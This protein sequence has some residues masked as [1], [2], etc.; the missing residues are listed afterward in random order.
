MVGTNKINQ[1]KTYK[2]VTNDGEIVEFYRTKATA[3]LE[4]KELE[5]L[6]MQELKIRWCA[7]EYFDIKIPNNRFE[8]ALKEIIS[9]KFVLTNSLHGVIICQAYNIPYAISLLPG[10]KLDAR[11]KWDDLAGWL[12]IKDKLIFVKNYK[13]GLKWWKDVG[14]KVKVSEDSLDKLMDCFPYGGY[15]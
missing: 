1:P 12:G 10:E 9:Y 14:S 6:H 7:D 3:V 5:K 11:D 13:E 8:S 15:L 2:I 4:I